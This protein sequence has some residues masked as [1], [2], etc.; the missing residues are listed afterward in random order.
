MKFAKWICLILTL[1]CLTAC[2]GEVRQ[3]YTPPQKVETAA[4]PE[5][6]APSV[7]AD[8]TIMIDGQQIEPGGVYFG[9]K[10]FVEWDMLSGQLG[11]TQRPEFT[12]S[13]DGRSFVSLDEACREY[14]GLLLKDEA[15]HHVY[16]LTKTGPW[17][18]P[19]GYRVPVLMYHGVSD[20]M[21]GMTALFV[22]PADMEAQIKY[23][24]DN[25]YTTI[26]FEDLVHVDEIEKPVILTYDDGYA[27]NYHELF[28]ILKKYNVKATIFVVTGTVD[29]N[30]NFLTSQQVRELSDSGLVSIQS[31]TVTHPYLRG[32]DLAVQEYELR[33][34]WLDV[35]HMTGKAPNVICYPSGSFDTTTFD[36]A[37]TYYAMGINMNGL[38][39][40]TGED[41][42]LVDRFYIERNDSLR[43]V[44]DYIQ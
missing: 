6:T 8:F 43:T 3:P 44:I 31:H 36:L 16:F 2:G 35:A 39:Y 18:L 40:I 32:R 12:L 29:N 11:L 21:W 13:V 28:P 24:V 41:P 7:E 42:Y 20:D 15:R 23:L 17:E 22:S 4:Q 5:Q 34:S 37:K 9:G 10:M 25:G 1:M 38:D 19:E 26:W 27:D 30:P 14:E 33:Q